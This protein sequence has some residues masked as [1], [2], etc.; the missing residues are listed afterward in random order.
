MLAV[1][2][3]M[4]LLAGLMIRRSRQEGGT[5]FVKRSVQP[6]IDFE[7]GQEDAGGIY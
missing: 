4:K 7:G 1:L 6:G 2:M 5:G 3:P